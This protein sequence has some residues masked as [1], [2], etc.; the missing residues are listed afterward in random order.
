[1]EAVTWPARAGIAAA[2]ALAVWLAGFVQG[3]GRRPP[4]EVV[5]KTVDKVVYQDR[6]EYRD[7]VE[8]KASRAQVIRRVIHVTVAPDGT[9]TR[10]VTIDKATNASQSAQV[11]AQGQRTKS[12]AESHEVSSTTVLAPRW[13]FGV[14]G[15][16]N[17]AA[18]L[19][20]ERKWWLG[21]STTHAFI[22]RSSLG[23]VFVKAQ[24]QPTFV[25]VVVE[26]VH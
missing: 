10:D 4:A 21:G 11:E 15:G 18:A 17:A 6:V 26:V 22:G 19:G 12:L 25:G 24:D 8:V 23:G 13:R 20:A 16:V 9:T 1:V 7:R 3:R 2:A 14:M 5:T